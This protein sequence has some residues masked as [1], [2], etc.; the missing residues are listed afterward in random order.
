MYFN[1]NSTV[2]FKQQRS[3]ALNN[4]P[5]LLWFTRGSL[6]GGPFLGLFL[7]S[8]PRF[9]HSTVSIIALKHFEQA[10]TNRHWSA[11]YDTFRD[12]FNR[13]CFAKERSIKE[14]ICSFFKRRQ[15]EH[16]IFHLGNTETRDPKYFSLFSQ[17]IQSSMIIKAMSK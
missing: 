1:F 2:F 15:H 10:R 8:C 7:C 16:R 5:C 17:S 4:M 11:H 12:N 9:G 13:V 6:H 3:S 14:M